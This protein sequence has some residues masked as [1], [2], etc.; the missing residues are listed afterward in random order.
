MSPDRYFTEVTFRRYTDLDK[1]TTIMCKTQA[2]SVQQQM[3]KERTPMN[4]FLI[5]QIF[6]PS[7]KYAPAQF[8][9][10]SNS[11]V[12]IQNDLRKIATTVFFAL[13]L[14]QES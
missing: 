13:I 14:L 1:V 6:K 2:F 5:F 12:N 7:K 4:P 8:F 9:S 11:L 10:C 3:V